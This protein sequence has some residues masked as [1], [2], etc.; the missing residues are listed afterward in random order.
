MGSATRKRLALTVWCL[1][2]RRPTSI[3]LAASSSWCRN[4]VCGCFYLSYPRLL[5]L[6]IFTV[7]ETTED[8]GPL[9]IVTWPW[10]FNSNA[11]CDTSYVC[12]CKD[13]AVFTSLIKK[14]INPLYLSLI[15][16][17]IWKWHILMDAVDVI[18]NIIIT[19]MILILFVSVALI[20]R[21]RNRNILLIQF[22]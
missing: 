5:Q 16:T 22:I 6:G 9:H 13:G 2:Q 11:W 14:Y 15:I 3:T 21:Q 1:S 17:N 12:C 19:V 7:T 4:I 18:V 10:Y 20:W 8:W